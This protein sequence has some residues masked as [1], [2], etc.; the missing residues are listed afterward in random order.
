MPNKKF[1][2]IRFL[3]KVLYANILLTYSGGV[4]SVTVIVVIMQM[5]MM[6]SVCRWVGGLSD[7]FFSFLV[8]IQSRIK[9]GVSS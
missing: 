1:I 8:Y 7:L 3:N 6:T 9:R 4:Y 2:K 5:F